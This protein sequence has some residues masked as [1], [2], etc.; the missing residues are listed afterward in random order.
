V[1]RADAVMQPVL[2]GD[3]LQFSIIKFDLLVIT[4]LPR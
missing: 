4:R 1:D 3:S 2:I